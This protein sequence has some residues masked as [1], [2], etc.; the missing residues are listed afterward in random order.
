MLGVGPQVH[1]Q[2]TDP[3]GTFARRAIADLA[4][5]LSVEVT[6]VELVKSEAVV[7]PDASLGCPLPGMKYRQV[8]KDGYRILLRAGG[9]IYSY[10][11]DGRRGPF[12]C[13]RSVI[14]EGNSPLPPRMNPDD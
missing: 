11:G 9:R 3:L 10:H 1:G 14:P 4:D 8:P 12:Y 6:A 5:R 2:H 13:A 7:W